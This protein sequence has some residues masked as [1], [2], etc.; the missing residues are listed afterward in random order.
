VREALQRYADRGV[1]R[2]FSVGRTRGGADEYRF[3]WLTREPMMIRFDSV[4]RTLSFRDLLPGVTRGSA[5][6]ADVEALIDSRRSAS[7]P[8]HR[9]IDRQ[10]ADVGCVCQRR[11]LS[12]DVRFRGGQEAYAVQRGVNLVNEIFVLLQASHPEYLWDAFGLPAE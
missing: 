7:V 10:R 8:A 1:F 11:R 12:I 6:M 5:V 2:V 3:T 4:A 9:R